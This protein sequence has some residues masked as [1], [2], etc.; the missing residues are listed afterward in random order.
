MGKEGGGDSANNGQE[1]IFISNWLLK[2][3]KSHLQGM[4]EV[5]K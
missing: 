3:K 1:S 2:A 4:H 5:C